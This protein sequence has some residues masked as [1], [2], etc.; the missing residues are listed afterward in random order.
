MARFPILIAL[1]AALGLAACA[2]PPTPYQAGGEGRHGYF[3]DQID[4]ETWRVRFSGNRATDRAVVEDYVLYRAAEITLAQGADGFVVIRQEVEKDVGYYGT[5]HYPHS[6]IYFGHGRG[7]YRSR[8]HFGYGFG[9]GTSSLRPVSSYTDHLRIRMFRDQAPEGL[10]ASYDAEAI[11]R[12]MGPKIV[13][14]VPIDG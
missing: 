5:I 3:E 6:G 12:V 4:P 14:P 1:A 2:T 10:G 13:R 7:G 8:S 11:M 9:Y